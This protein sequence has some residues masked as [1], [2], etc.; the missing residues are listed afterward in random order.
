MKR[1][2]PLSLL[3]LLFGQVWSNARLQAASQIRSVHWIF[4]SFD[5]FG[6]YIVPTTT[7]MANKVPVLENP[8]ALRNSQVNSLESL[9]AGE[10]CAEAIPISCGES[11]QFNLGLD[12]TLQYWTNTQCLPSGDRLGKNRHYSITV[13]N[14][15]DLQ[16]NLDQAQGAYSRI[17]V[18]QGCFPGDGRYSIGTCYGQDEGNSSQGPS[19][20]LN[21][22]EAGTY[23]IGIDWENIDGF[24]T[25][26]GSDFV[27]SVSCGAANPC[28]SSATTL[29][30]GQTRNDNN[31]SASNDFDISTY[32]DCLNA[33]HSFNARDRLYRFNTPAGASSV[34]FSLTGLSADLNLFVY[35]CGAT[36]SCLGA[37]VRSG[38]QSESITI[39]NPSG[40]FYLIVD[41]YNSSQLSSYQLTASCEI[42]LNNV[43]LSDPIPISC[44][45]SV[46]GN[47]S[48]ASNNFDINMYQSCSGS[49]NPQAN[50]FN[51]G[52]VVYGVNVDGPADLK[53]SLTNLQTD[54]DL[55]IYRCPGGEYSECLTN[56]QQLNSGAT[57]ESISI[58][59]ANGFYYIIVDGY[60]PSQAG[61]YR[62]SV[63]CLKSEDPCASTF[64][65]LSCGQTRTGSTAGYS[66]KFNIDVYEDCHSSSNSFT[67]P[68]RMYRFIT[69]SD[70]SSVTFTLSGLSA[71]LDLFLYDC[72]DNGYCL[73]NST[74]SNNSAESITINNPSGIYYLIIDGYDASQVSSFSLQAT[75]TYV[76]DDPCNSPSI[77]IS[78]NQTV[79]GSNVETGNNFYA[80]I[81]QDCHSTSSL[82]NGEDLVYRLNV[83]NGT[84]DLRI[85]LSN[86][87]ANLDLFLYDCSGANS[88]ISK[89]SRSGTSA[90]EIVL[91]NPSGTYYIIIDAANASTY[92]NFILTTECCSDQVFSRCDG[93]SHF[94]N[95][96]NRNY[97]FQAALPDWWQYTDGWTWYVNG[98]SVSNL[99]T[100]DLNYTFLVNGSYEVCYTYT[101]NDTGCDVSCCN[102]FCVTNLYG[103]E[104]AI[105]E[106]Y[107]GEQYQFNLAVNQAQ[108]VVWSMVNAAGESTFIGDGL[109]SDLVNT[110]PSCPVVRIC[111]QYFDPTAGCW[112]TCCR[113]IELCPP[114]DCCAEDPLELSWLQ[115]FLDCST[116]SCGREIY[117]CTYQGQ[118]IIDIKDDDSRC[119]DVLGR[120]YNCD[121]ELLFNYGGIGGINLD[122]AAQITDCELIFECPDEPTDGCDDCTNCFFYQ[123]RTL[124]NNTVSFYNNYC[125]PPEEDGQQLAITY[126]WDFFDPSGEQSIEVNYLNGTSANSA[127]P[128]CDFPGPGTYRVCI[129]VYRALQEGEEFPTLLYTCCQEIIIGELPCYEAPHAFFNVD[130]I[131][132]SNQFY[133]DGSVSEGG[134]SYTWDIPAGVSYTLIPGAQGAYCEFP[135]NRC[136]TICLLVNNECG[137]S[138]YCM[139]FCSTESC[140]GDPP[141]IPQVSPVVEGQQVRFPTMPAGEAWGPYEWTVP[142]SANFVNETSA[143]SS[144]PVIEFLEAGSY[145]ICVTFF[146]GCH[147]VCWCWTVHVQNPC[148][149]SDPLE[150]GIPVF[151]TNVGHTSRFN[152]SDYDCY[153]YSS[154]FS[155]PDRLY[156]ITKESAD[157]DLTISLFNDRIEGFP[158]DL[159]L[160]LLDSCG[161]PTECL[162]LSRNPFGW[163]YPSLNFDAIHLPNYPAGTYYLVVDGYNTEQ[164]GSFRLTSTCGKLECPEET[165]DCG[166]SLSGSTVGAA[167][168]VSAYACQ[169]DNRKGGYTGPERIYRYVA[170]FDG[171]V[172]INLRDLS[173]EVD[174]DL[175]ILPACDQA[176][177]CLGYGKNPKGQSESISLNVQAG[178]DYYLVVEGW[179]GS[180]GTFTLE[181]DHPTCEE[182]NTCENLCEENCCDENCSNL[183]YQYEEQPEDGN[184]R[185]LF[186]NISDYV[187]CKWELDGI[188][189]PSSSNLNS[190][191]LALSPGLHR[192]CIYLQIPGQECVIKCC[193]SIFVQDPYL[194]GDNIIDYQYIENHG[195][196]FNLAEDNDLE[197]ISWNRVDDETPLGSGQQSNILPFPNVCQVATIAVTYYNPSTQ[198]WYTCYRDIWLCPPTICGDDIIDYRYEEEQYVFSLNVSENVDPASIQWTEM[199]SGLDFG[200]G[201]LI[202]VYYPGQLPCESRTICVTYYN[203][204]TRSWQSCCR[205]VYLCNPFQCPVISWNYVEES[206]GYQFY[207]PAS[208]S[209]TD[210]SWRIESPVNTSLGTGFTSEL[211][212]I[213]N[214]CPTYIISVYYYDLNCSCWRVCSIEFEACPPAGCC[215]ENPLELNWLQSLISC[216]ERPC[217]LQ[218]YCCTYL[219]QAVIDIRDDSSQCTDGRGTVYDCTGEP[220]F[221]Y[222]G[223][224]GE[225]GDLAALLTNCQLI[226]ECPGPTPEICND[227]I[228]NDND[229][230]IDCADPDCGFEIIV[231]GDNSDCSADNGTATVIVPEQV[232]VLSIQWSN[233]A[234]S[235]TISN[236]APGIYTVIVT[237]TNGCTA[238]G[239]IE[240]EEKNNITVIATAN[241]P[242]ICQ[243]EAIT[244]GVI[245][246]GGIPPYTYDWGAALGSGQQQIVTPES[247]TTYSV[248]VTDSNGCEATDEVIVIVNPE[249]N[250]EII[251]STCDPSLETYRVQV[252]T[253]PGT[254]LASSHGTVVDDG[255]GQFSVT[256]VPA[257]QEITLTCTLLETECIK[258]IVVPAPACVCPALPAPT[259]GPFPE[260]CV[261]DELPSITAFVDEGLQVDWYSAASG[262]QPL[263]QNSSTYIPTEVGTFY[264]ETFDPINNCTSG[265]RTPVSIILHPLPEII[266]IGDTLLCAG[267]ETI[268]TASGA[269]S[270]QWST[271]AT[272]PSITVSES[273][274]YT[275]EGIDENG[276]SN[277]ATII[278]IVTEPL[279]GDLSKED[280]LCF[281]ENNGRAS[282]Q[283][284]GGTAPYQYQW[285]NGSTTPEIENLGP[286]IYTVVVTDAND[287]TFEDSI[288]ILEA[289]ELEVVVNPT[290]PDCG[291]L[292]NGAIALIATGGVAPYNYSWSDD[293]N[294]TTAQRNELA[295][296]SYSCTITDSE[297]CFV[298]ISVDLVN[299]QTL[300]LELITTDLTCNG[301]NSGRIEAVVA[302]GTAP[303][304]YLWSN[305]STD[306]IIDNVPANLVFSILVTD[307]LGCTITGEAILSEPTSLSLT[308]SGTDLS[309]Q[310]VAD[311]RVAVIATGGTPPYTYLWNGSET[312]RELNDLAAGTYTVVVS[313]ANQCQA[314]GTLTIE[315]PAALSIEGVVTNA[316]SCAGT[317][318]GAIDI[319]VTGGT[320][321]YSFLWSN[322]STSEDLANLE[323]GLYTLVVTDANAC[324]LSRSFTVTEPN[325]LL[326]NIDLTQPAC[327]GSADGSVALSI[328]GGLPPYSVE[329]SDGNTAF[330]RFALAAGVYSFVVT[331]ANQCSFAGQAILEG[332]LPLSLTSEITDI[333]CAGINDGSIQIEISGGTGPYSYSWNNGSVTKDVEGLSAGQ[334]MVQIQDANGCSLTSTVFTISDPTEI[335][336]SSTVNPV[337]ACG[338]SMDGAITTNVTGGS[339]PYIYNWSNASSEN[340][341]VDLSPG[342]Y[343]LTLVDQR[344][345]EVI[346][347]RV[348]AQAEEFVVQ[349]IIEQPNC[350]GQAT[351]SILLQISGGIAP[352]EILWDNEHTGT[353]RDAL[354]AGTYS[355]VVRDASNCETE[356]TVTIV[357]PTS[358]SLSANIVEPSCF[359]SSDGSITATASGGSGGYSYLWST[360]ENTPTISNLAPGAYG[361]AISDSQ[362]C[363]LDTTLNLNEPTQILILDEIIQDATCA[364]QNDGTIRPTVTGGVGDL[365]F[366]WSH[367]PT[368]K[369]VTQLAA[370]T[371][372]L[373]ITDANQCSITKE[374][375]ISNSTSYTLSANSNAANCG[376]ANGSINLTIEGGSAPFQFDWDIDGNG[377]NDDEQSPMNLMGGT[378]AVTVTDA[379]GCVVVLEEIVVE[380][381][382]QPE[383]NILSITP[384]LCEQATG[385]VQIEVSG[386]QDPYTF[387]W[388]NG[389]SQQDLSDVP[390]DS[391]TL[392]LTDATACAVTV[393]VEVSCVDP[394]QAQTGTMDQNQLSACKSETLMATYDNSQEVIGA[395]EVRVFI[396]HD[397]SGTSLGNRVFSINTDPVVVYNSEMVLGQEYYI[398]AVV[399][400]ED[401]NGLVDLNSSCLAVAAGTPFVFVE[402]PEGPSQLLVSNTNVC[403]GNELILNLIVPVGGNLTYLWETPRGN[404]TTEAPTLVLE[405]FQESDEGE[406]LASYQLGSC[407]SDQIGPL[408]IGLEERTKLVKAGEDLT[409]CTDNSIE[410]DGSLPP[411]TEGTWYTTSPA[412][413]A[414]KNNPKTRVDSLVNGENMFVW[415]ANIGDCVVRDTM[416]VYH[417]VKPTTKAESITMRADQAAIL[418][419]KSVLFDA[420]TRT[421]PNDQLEFS[422]ISEPA[423]GKLTIDSVGLIYERDFDQEEDLDMSFTY[424][425]CNNDP[426]CGQLCSSAEISLSVK[427]LND[428][429]IDY[430]KALRPGGN[431]PKWE[432]TLLRKV[433]KAELWIV[434]RW[435]K[436]IYHRKFQDGT[437]DLGKGRVLEGWDG[438][439]ESGMLM[440]AG[441]YYFL[442]EGLPANGDKMLI[443]R[444]IIYLLK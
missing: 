338:E 219:G 258:I 182:I 308:L 181:I 254:V 343:T 380:E 189:I 410:L 432:F 389:S 403:K 205:K 129:K 120:V 86:L 392:T 424:Q 172:T 365:Q 138:S 279:V 321:S 253:E 329:W 354:V 318:D 161:L 91:N 204:S 404:F 301:S 1:L 149:E 30:C 145:N 367:G 282:I 280:I 328:S 39:N 164:Q 260:I 245:V 197:L 72:S 422:I 53:V 126:Q 225:N 93:I 187:V 196:R 400:K 331:D 3:F 320:G 112:R 135:P 420:V 109:L 195:Y 293:N 144:R 74:N 25:S 372:E 334:Y 163:P 95:G 323:A 180:Q 100:E 263:L 212:E 319:T 92:S 265:N 171:Q 124:N 396:V 277:Q 224:A 281:G 377:D 26:F 324:E 312:D 127:N 226:Y 433:S 262:G 201:Q 103:C 4:H 267:E 398:S 348:L 307:A 64:T 256:A 154:S 232:S 442:F 45:Q 345:C 362:G 239:S 294:A 333:S 393:T 176:S 46:T 439:D 56:W 241:P 49:V 75:C 351:A 148:L 344:G 122:L 128:I 306:R 273:G 102:D 21:N 363:F 5:E 117:C 290:H 309:C 165:I 18:F 151:D 179:D 24:G 223:I 107:V 298:I 330:E 275:V 364:G 97:T 22:L 160:F 257:G 79:S 33:E 382:G 302:G 94:R 248:T 297:N 270:Y 405:N 156:E 305:Q 246:N 220:L 311:G 51:A 368:T 20:S 215:A 43:C 347:S 251:T 342:E 221:S 402:S 284:S 440:Y 155:A 146:N 177:S 261:G 40:T 123:P 34:N 358:L 360:G 199:E 147:K 194:C 47:T 359:G 8:P 233:G 299:E 31:F 157:G 327:S 133:L 48:T 85:R 98:Q 350:A 210:V 444:G 114:Y 55:F 369:D 83:P 244:L 228:D 316:T 96:N 12:P 110:D 115:P 291:N 423:Y 434:D 101:S 28:T 73:D 395:G 264:A 78:C 353:L 61:P 7:R 438:R 272:T 384:S 185:Y 249:P 378:Y 425:I 131:T 70:V 416:Y 332:P 407:A 23:I 255:N 60:I 134:Q 167:N 303:Y 119:T 209:I 137:Q 341:L 207:I 276:C 218:V 158:L 193:K 150:C 125:N 268:C 52:D 325:E 139:E 236:L 296:G 436:K 234:N 29:S 203:V 441:A 429:L 130:R 237:D 88:C 370:G 300:S 35:R 206:E 397:G 310:D 136:T 159:D 15:T 116:A 326:V 118:T 271:G 17:M 409:A 104:D 411:D 278:I 357:D 190:L 6:Q 11:V 430:P 54:L 247:T 32:S 289:A 84:D 65:N 361:L 385:K 421:I 87:T 349:E 286:G 69:P 108:D 314:E 113:D 336:I 183:V 227:G 71:N 346:H 238:T 366:Q 162:Q 58:P 269:S 386:G 283:V 169:A 240:I 217:G 443:E 287:C 427:F 371:Y 213:G 173:P 106:A 208:E 168:N 121:G 140:Y 418:L 132:E 375:T 376:A 406:Y 68:D 399:G 231:I 322:G 242:L 188:E 235:S 105:V 66:N 216:V 317:P 174:L 89:S 19:L 38:N 292:E 304:Q 184:R 142:S 428:E 44:G 408:V 401:V 192:I 414:E 2:L 431:N 59:N 295:A 50:P 57:S 381:L 437:D 111:A 198:C 82:Y 13:P 211:L 388:S 153:E 42:V 178:E 313:D 383:I 243:G 191:S 259:P 412:I 252:S 37:S 222:G 274:T 214:P 63:E 337:S 379:N 373:L 426:V 175:L 90:E 170:T 285:S 67:G 356:R 202:D 62:L 81:Y 413:I 335:I 266:I 415:V 186:T 355:Y 230:L 76:S 27:L 394:C 340:N 41:G 80:D 315:A 166:D 16:I 10:T 339:P 387:L 229:G 36:P 390:A 99:G 143:T 391:Y 288:E 250:I 374:Y 141:S 77:P 152:A 435:G 200:Q 9:A 352:Y 14:N 419:N 417:A